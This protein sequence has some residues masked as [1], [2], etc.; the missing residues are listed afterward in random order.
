VR[1]WPLRAADLD[2]VGHVNNAALWQALSE[3]VHSPVRFVS[4]TH[5]QSIER[6]DAVVLASAPGSVWLVVDGVT[7]VSATYES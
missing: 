2:I 5:H 6:D 3:V 7:K 1:P 4:V